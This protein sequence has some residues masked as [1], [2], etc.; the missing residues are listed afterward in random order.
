MEPRELAPSKPKPEEST[1]SSL[2]KSDQ[3]IANPVTPAKTV[4]NE[5]EKRIKLE[6]GHV[7]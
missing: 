6:E 5:G 2:L 3:V 1:N 7:C 4:E